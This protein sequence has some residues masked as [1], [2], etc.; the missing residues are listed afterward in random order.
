ML[1]LGFVTTSDNL[2]TKFVSIVRAKERVVY[3]V[4]Y[5]KLARFCKVS[6]LVGHE[7]KECG[8]GIHEER[9]MKFGD[10]LYAE[11]PNKP[12]SDSEQK[13]RASNGGSGVRAN[14]HGSHTVRVGVDSGKQKL[15]PEVSDTAASPAKPPADSMDEDRGTRKRLNMDADGAA[16]V[17]AVAVNPSGLLAITDGSG[18]DLE[19]EFFSNGQL[20]Q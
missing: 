17:P 1:G 10:W 18:M 14:P 5:E 13:E 12:R 15:G 6:G 9:S 11:A 16:E 3:L 7:F 4:R 2:L 20:K 19:G 8:N